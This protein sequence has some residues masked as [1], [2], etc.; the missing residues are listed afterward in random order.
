[1]PDAESLKVAGSGERWRIDGA[2]DAAGLRLCN[3]YLG[4]LADHTGNDPVSTTASYYQ[5]LGSVQN[6]GLLPETVQYVD[7]VF[8]LRDRYRG[9]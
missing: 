7:S 4:Y 5:G 1:M 3:D 9:G 2:W 8:A 6:G